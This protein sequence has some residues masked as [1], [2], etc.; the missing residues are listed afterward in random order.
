VGTTTST[1]QAVNAFSRRSTWR[2]HAARALV[3]AFALAFVVLPVAA[4]AGFLE[5]EW[6]VPTTNADG[7]ALLDLQGYRVYTGTSVPNCPGTGFQS[8][9]APDPSP[10]PGQTFPATLTGLTAGTTYWIRVSAVDTSGNESACTTAV[11]GLAHADVDVTPASLG[12]GSVNIGSTPTLDF[13]V[14]NI[15][16]T[17]LTGTVTTSAPFSITLGGTLNVAPGASQVVRVRFAPQAAQVFAGSVVFT[18]SGDDVSRPV[19]GTGV[20]VTPAV[21]QF[22]QSG[23]AVTEGSPATITVSR[24]GGNHGGVTVAYATSN[25]TAGSGDYTAASG[26]LTFGAG[27]MSQTF[28]VNTTNDTVVEPAETVTLTLSNPQGG[29]SLGTPNPATLTIN[30]N[31]TA[32]SVQFSAA[33]YS[34]GEGGGNVTLTVTRTGGTAS[35]VTVAYATANGSATA[36][37]DYSSRSGTLTFNAG[38]TSQ[39]FTV[40]ILQDTLPEGAE[41]FTVTLSNPGGGAT[42]GATTVA[43]VTI[44]DDENPAAVLQF[45]Q[46]SYT[47]AEGSAATITVTRTGGTQGGVTVNYTT[48]NGTA[49]AGQDYTVASGT[50]SF[51]AGVTSRAFTV[52]TNQDSLAEAAETVTLTLSN[53]Q[54]GGVLGT[55]NPSTLT[56][57]DNDVAGTV[58][59]GSA[60]YSVN[61][62]AGSVTLTVT[63]TGGSAG[64]VSVAYATANGSA[65]AGADYSSRSGTLTF[66]AGVTSLPIVVPVL[67]DSVV[68]GGHTF[69]VTLSNPGGGAALGA[70]TVATVTINDDEVSPSVVQFGQ[71]SYTVV[72]GGVATIT[73]TRTGSTHGGV[74]VSYAT[75]DGSATAGADYTTTSGTLT[76]AANQMSRTFTVA[77]VQD[78]AVEAAETITLTLSNP[79]GGATLGTPNPATL[80]ITDNDVAGTVQLGAAAY[81]VAEGAGNVT[82]TVTRTG[83]AASGVTVDYATANGSATAGADYGTRSGTLTF[84]AGVTS[85]PIVIPIVQDSA[86]EGSETFT[87]TLTNAGGGAALG[88]TTVTTVTITDDEPTLRFSA[89]TYTVAETAGLATITV[90]RVGPTTGPLSIDWAT[91]GAGTA[92]A[93][94][95]F[96]ATSGTLSF[97]PGQTSR[98]FTVPVLDDDVVDGPKTVGLQLANPSGAGLG[99]PSTAT[100]TIT[101]NDVAGSIQ[102]G[103]VTYVADE[104]GGTFNVPVMRT[105]GA[106]AGVTASYALTGGSAALGVDFTMSGTGTVTFG[107]GATMATIQVVPMNDSLLEGA[108]TLE[109]SL[110]SPAGGAALGTIRR[111]MITIDEVAFEFTPPVYTVAEGGVATITVTR[112]GPTVRSVSVDWA[113]S[114]GTAVA[115]AD[116][117]AGSGRLTFPV[118]VRTRTFTVATINDTVVEGPETVLLTLRNPSVGS[119][120]GFQPTAVLTITDNDAGGTIAFAGA[121]HLVPENRGTYNVPVVRAGG[122]ASSV[123]VNYA[124]TGGTATGGGV[125][126]TLASGTITFLAG[127]TTATIPIT[128]VDDTSVESDESIVLQL[129]NPTGGASLGTPSAATV[130]ITDNDRA[131]TVQFTVATSSILEGAGSAIVTVTRT[132]APT[133]AVSVVLSTSNG[134]ATA[135]ID[136]SPVSTL[137]DFGAGVTSRTVAIPIIPNNAVDGTRTVNLTLSGATAPAAVGKVGSAVLSILD[138][139]S[140]LE[141]TAAG[142]S[143]TEG[144]AAIITVR[145]LGSPLGT[146]SVNY[147]ITGGTATAGADYTATSGRLTFGP[148]VMTRTFTVSTL[149]DTVIESAETIQLALSAPSGN[150]VIGAVGTTTLTVNDSP[151]TVKFGAAVYTVTEA[152]P[153]A[154]ITVLRAG[155]TTGTVT[156]NYARTGGT[157]TG[158]G[159]DYTFT[160]GT[161]TFGPGVTSRTFT[162]AITNDTASEGPETV[163]FGLSN[164]VGAAIG[165]PS[166]TTLTIEDNEPQ[167]KFAAAAYTVTEGTPTVTI[168]V[169]RTGVT[170]A[171]VTVAYARTGG[172]ATGNGTDYAFTPGTLSFAPGVASRTFTVAITNDTLAEAPETVV[173]GLSGATNATIGTPSSTTLTILDNE[174]QVRFSAATYTVSEATPTVVISVLR[175][176]PTTGTVTVDYA[177]TSGTASSPQDYTVGGTGTLTFGPGVTTQTFSLTLNNDSLVEAAETIGLT[178]GNPVNASLGT[179]AVATVNLTSNDVAGAVQFASAIFSRDQAGATATITVVRQFG[180]ASGVTVQV[181]TV[182]GS[183]VAGTHYTAVA[184]TL[185]FEAGQ[186]ATSFTVPILNNGNDPAGHWLGLVLSAPG[187]GA[188]LGPQST[189]VLW[190]VE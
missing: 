79:Q 152:T 170:T 33:T 171:P 155:P 39:T 134:T 156:V 13:T 147:A 127:Q 12:F 27:V 116:Y 121:T 175:T 126:Y 24:T 55:P 71:A 94:V 112:T 3:L 160:P 56:I 190:V 57:T 11:S 37:A 151:P 86:V 70:T 158:N 131:A 10:S 176:G 103:A 108:K 136:Y 173:F 78:A 120:R 179:P 14:Q 64:G 81:T 45:S 32:G 73:V 114:D 50:L 17:T 149:A 61:E 18:T 1:F 172:T 76:F 98:T 167:V 123:T 101:D 59:L 75:S 21:L 142:Y 82:V 26:T 52:T 91:T 104:G 43:T 128:I 95:D 2:S 106:A 66:N 184:G 154:T 60:T 53:P 157:A 102:F 109:L 19:S 36:G 9:G 163:I 90:T 8:L 49:T 113:T 67:Q 44:N 141:F 15:G 174:P 80:T 87:V 146:V 35:G 162:V 84:N 99:T 118:G 178:L 188:T 137:I 159:T 69:T 93:G 140:T 63:R 105:G 72:E 38:V 115:G 186:T 30:D 23:Y 189:A 77:T 144:A 117:A 40:P 41:T 148:N 46:A 187:G 5:I 34:V 182:D 129:S 125:D 47:V 6:D 133:T 83:G 100:L 153:T 107:K 68:E 74:V 4:E 130:V 150:A 54:G 181:A 88:A 7:S 122:I 22:S 143:V 65:T 58:Q 28:T 111:T 62:G 164:A 168:T 185:T 31:D 89:A 135:G 183:A 29:A 145:R 85:L 51:G 25:G 96:T 138:D 16:A 92:T 42:L 177:A 119:I 48:S 124:V 110:S 180:L 132:G 139:D 169:T 20:V 166:S 165:T 97:A 161:L